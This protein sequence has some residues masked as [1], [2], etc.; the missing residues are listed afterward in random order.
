MRGVRERKGKEDEME[1]DGKE[2]ESMTR[3][4]TMKKEKDGEGWDGKGDES[5]VW[6]DP[7]TRIHQDIE[8]TSLRPRRKTHTLLTHVARANM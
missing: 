4:L 8:T 1:K 7:E 5:K 2:K 3:Y 6:P